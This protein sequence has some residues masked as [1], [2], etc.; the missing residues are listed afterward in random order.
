MMDYQFLQ[1]LGVGLLTSVFVGLLTPVVRR[2]AIRINALDSPAASHKTHI[3]PVPYLGGVAIAAGVLL[4][5]LSLLLITNQNLDNYVLALQVLVPA[6][7]ISAMGLWDDL[8][9]L[10]PW[11][12]LITQTGMAIIVACVIVF[13]DTVGYAFFNPILN[14]LLSIFWIVGVCNSINFFDNLDGGAAGTVSVITICI[15][16]IAFNRGQILIS[17]LSII[18]AGA[19]LGFLFWN[20]SPA[21]IYMGDAGA[22]FL[23]IIVSVLTIRLNPGIVPNYLSLAIPLFLLAVPI[24]DTSVAVTSRL[25]RGISPL[26]GGR[27]HLSHRLIRQGLSRRRVAFWLWG[28]SGCFGIGACL[29]YLFPQELGISIAIGGLIIWIALFYWFSRISTIN[30]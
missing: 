10:A 7:L 4:V 14:I 15:F 27:D 22:L 20:K 3:H 11:P 1:F 19:T 28:L 25:A 12:R 16:F 24:L 5:T 6:L 18:T 9:G 21:K 23:G 17:A 29:I 26:T 2:I 13:T 30:E 8:R